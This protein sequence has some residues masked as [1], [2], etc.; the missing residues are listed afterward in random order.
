ML[1][2][3]LK[4]H[5]HQHHCTAATVLERLKLQV[6]F[7][8]YCSHC[9]VAF[10]PFP[11]YLCRCAFSIMQVLLC[12]LSGDIFPKAQQAQQ[13]LASS[14]PAKD[15]HL[16]QMLGLVGVWVGDPQAAVHQAAANEEA[17]LLD[18]CRSGPDPV[19]SPVH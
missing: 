10:V 18:A 7:L 12:S 11:S 2:A 16:R 3:I 4:Q 15:E 13:R 17:P 19:V 1:Q 5:L 8:W 9:A 14:S 6:P